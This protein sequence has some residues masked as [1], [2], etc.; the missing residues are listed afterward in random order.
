[1]PP[2]EDNQAQDDSP[3]TPATVEPTGDESP[4]EVVQDQTITETHI[5]EGPADDEDASDD[6]DSSEEE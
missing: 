4:R 1:M 5:Q 3:T 6:E 2:E